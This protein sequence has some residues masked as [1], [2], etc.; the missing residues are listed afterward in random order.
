MN[1]AEIDESIAVLVGGHPIAIIAAMKDGNLDRENEWVASD[2]FG[3][4]MVF[5]DDQGDHHVRWTFHAPEPTPEAAM[6]LLV[7][8][9]MALCQALL[10]T[11][12]GMAGQEWRHLW[13]AV[14]WAR[15]S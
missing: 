15:M 7:F 13:E 3:V 8:G 10:R 9:A 4:A 1:M 2:M 6:R 12:T 11:A 14:S 5:V